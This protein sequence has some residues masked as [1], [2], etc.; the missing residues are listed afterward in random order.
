MR[1]YKVRKK[2]VEIIIEDSLSQLEQMEYLTDLLDQIFCVVPNNLLTR[3][4]RY[5][6]ND[7]IRGV[8][9][10]AVQTSAQFDLARQQ[11]IGK[12]GDLLLTIDGFTEGLKFVA[13][14]SAETIVRAQTV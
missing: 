2:R 11:F 9:K 13:N 6:L 14:K 5:Q 12:D 10:Y 4:D 7:T 8:Q 3:R 1:E